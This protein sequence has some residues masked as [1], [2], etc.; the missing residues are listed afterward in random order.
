MDNEIELLYESKGIDIFDHIKELAID[1]ASARRWVWELL[2][3]AVDI[4]V[5]EQGVSAEFILTDSSAIFK[6]NGLPFEEKSLNHLFFKKSQKREKR[7]GEITIGNFGTGFLTTHLLSKK[8]EISGIYKTRNGVFTKL[9][10][11]NLDRTGNERDITESLKKY[12]ISREK[13]E[14]GVVFSYDPHSVENT[15]F[16]YIFTHPGSLSSGKKGIEDLKNSLSF[17]IVFISQIKRLQS[18]RVKNTLDSSDETYFLD[19]DNYHIVSELQIKKVTHNNERNFIIQISDDVTTVAMP[20]EF[21][22]YKKIK[23][24][25]KNKQTP[26]LFKIFPLIGSENFGFPTIVNSLNFEPTK[27]REGI[28]LAGSEIVASQIETN[29]KLILDAVSLFQKLV[30]IISTDK[31]HEWECLYEFATITC[32]KNSKNL[33]DLEWY[34][35]FVIIPIRKT[36][37]GLP[38]VRLETKDY[39]LLENALFPYI[40]YSREELLLEFWQIC[41]EYIGAQIPR[42][43]DIL[44]W[45]KILHANYEEWTKVEEKLDFKYDIKRLLQDIETQGMIGSLANSKFLGSE[46]HAIM[47]LNK[48][49][50]FVTKNHE[51]SLFTTIR[52]IPNQLGEFRLIQDLISDKDTRIPNE[53]KL[54]LKDL[55]NDDWRRDLLHEEISCELS[56]SQ[57]TGVSQISLAIDSII[58][59]KNN[60]G[61]KSAVYQLIALYTEEFEEDEN[62][63]NWRRLIHRFASDIDHSVGDLIPLSGLIPTLWKKADEW[64]LEY[65][66][67]E[68]QSQKNIGNLRIKLDLSTEEES[69]KWL[70][71]FFE[72]CERNQKSRFYSDKAIFPNQEGNFKE[73]NGLSFDCVNSKLLKNI[74]IS[75][76][77]KNWYEQLL[78]E[79][80]FINKKFEEERPFTIKQVSNEINDRIKFYRTEYKGITDKQKEDLLESEILDL[81]N[82]DQ[83]IQGMFKLVSLLPDNDLSERKTILKFS[84]A[85]YP[86]EFHLGENATI[87]PNLSPDFEFSLTDEWILKKIAEELNAKSIVRLKEEYLYF[88]TRS[89]SQIVEWIDNLIS[90]ISGCGGHRH[91]FLLEE[92]E[93]IPNQNDNLKSIKF[94]QQDLGIPD[95]LK[96]IANSNYMKHDWNDHLLHKGALQSTSLFEAKDSVGLADIALE[97]DN[98]IRD[99]GEYD[100]VNRNFVEFINML[101]KSET[102]NLKENERLFTN[103][104][105]NKSILVLE[106]LGEGK[107]RSDIFDILQNREKL[108]ILAKLAKSPLS[109]KQL[110]N[111]NSAID[112]VG[113][114]KIN[115]LVN[116]AKVEKE[117]ENF[118]NSL[119][120]LAEKIF[121]QSLVKFGFK[122]ERTG[123][124][125]D[126]K[127]VRN[128]IDYFIEIKSFVEGIDNSVKMTSRQAQT[129]VSTAN[130]IL[131]VFPK[132][133]SIPTEADFTYKSRFVKN[134]SPTLIDSVGNARELEQQR[135]NLMDKV[136]GIIFEKWEYKYNISQ[137]IW[138]NGVDLENFIRHLIV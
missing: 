36:L 37:L 7:E 27:E 1:E 29:K 34:K 103:F 50:D 35:E 74:L 44:A 23:I 65:L 71:D 9:I 85:I 95:D 68:I 64:F 79:E 19:D 96:S 25:A 75:L 55:S 123:V 91:K 124:G 46:E 18:V 77:G 13:I 67:K 99:S 114:E 56:S 78:N 84:S 110:E 73:K 57:K 10:G 63:P 97:I 88:N 16:S 115:I 127:I 32:P 6:H 53:L 118:H 89:T 21:N 120:N 82:Y 2:Q 60:P 39:I 116:Q 101:L 108:D 61:I 62:N 24:L 15:I 66:V 119:G 106:T 47:W 98:A 134:I 83:F 54:I 45:S 38:I 52:V 5:S 26:N 4:A 70:N 40:P 132:T 130:Y 113:A 94:L 102:V 31:S 105:N 42:S 121:K 12:S 51:V 49:I 138:S 126:F 125:S 111:F 122:V 87:L 117:Q 107:V 43:Q 20:I 129:A 22:D 133:H 8:V 81:H 131:C 59:E 58:Q 90:F 86:V 3:N 17:A 137:S 14:E 41:F 80:I 48:V 109:I 135:M 28:I 100:R 11:V 112:I 128:N 136:I 33:V 93:I 72:F 69:V 92:F 104:H 30:Q 76:G